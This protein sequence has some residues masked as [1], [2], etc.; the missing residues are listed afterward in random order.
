MA[1]ISD[2]RCLY[3]VWGGTSLEHGDPRSPG[4]FFSF[5]CPTS[6]LDAE[7]LFAIAEFGNACL[8]VSQFDVPPG[9]P[10]LVGDVDPGD[11]VHPSL[12]GA[13]MQVFIQNPLAQ[14]L[15]RTGQASR[16]END[17]GGAS[18]YTGPRARPV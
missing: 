4:V 8:F 14:R 2:G 11:Y 7:R 5:Q 9:T 13:G 10:M 15:V 18:V 16:L 1:T 17:M 12:Q 3:R 6:R